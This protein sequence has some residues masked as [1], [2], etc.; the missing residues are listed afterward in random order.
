MKLLSILV[1]NMFLLTALAS[2]STPSADSGSEAASTPTSTTLAQSTPT[3]ATQ[4]QESK[5]T[6]N[7]TSAGTSNAP[8][9]FL[10]EELLTAEEASWMVG[11]TV[12]LT[13]VSEEVTETGELYTDYTYDFPSGSTV[14]ASLYFTQNALV[15][16]AELAKGHDAKWAF[17]ES[18]KYVEDQVVSIPDLGNEA[19][20]LKNNMEVS[21]LYKDYYMLIVFIMDNDDAATL[22][23]NKNI[24]VNI[25][26]KLK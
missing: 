13:S 11:Q 17:E 10:P 19:F 2:C 3:T 25:L 21:V 15:S 5:E 12:T 20:Y 4:T 7:V 1:L 18:K 6:K 24:A 9:I 8:Q 14:L 16:E 22:E 23:L 26:D